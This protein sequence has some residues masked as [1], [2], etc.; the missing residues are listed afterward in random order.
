VS[1]GPPL[2]LTR[3]VDA[4]PEALHEYRAAGGYEALARVRSGSAD[5][6][7]ALDDANLR[8]RGGAGFPV[9]RKWALARAADG[10]R[11]VVVANGGEHEPGSK[12]DRLLLAKYPHRVLEGVAICAQATGATEAYLYL[13]EDMTDAIGSAKAAVAE[14]TDAGLLGALAVRVALAPTTYVAGEETAA[15]EVHYEGG[16]TAGADTAAP[17]DW[18]DELE[19]ALLALE[20]KNSLRASGLVV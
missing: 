4:S 2:L 12:K 20:A 6:I 10:A 11:K 5:A 19:M 9:G 7:R 17:Y 13:I 16:G 15:L 8:G 3:P 14:A 18:E 1:S